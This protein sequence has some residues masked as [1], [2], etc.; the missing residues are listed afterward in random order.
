MSG[1]K[2]SIKP[3]GGATSGSSSSEQGVKV[4]NTN[5]YVGITGKYTTDK[6]TTFSGSVSKDFYKGKVDFPGGSEKFK[7]EGKPYFEFKV[8]KKFKNGG[9]AKYYKDII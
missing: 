8:E 2:L 6:G 7:G 9:I 4:K 3:F 1:K 5:A